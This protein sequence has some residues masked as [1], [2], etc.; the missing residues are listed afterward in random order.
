MFIATECRNL[1]KDGKEFRPRAH[2]NLTF[3][4]Q[5]I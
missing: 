1:Q 4:Y 2:Q 5:E 3:K